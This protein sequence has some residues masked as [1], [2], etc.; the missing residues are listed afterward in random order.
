MCSSDLNGV[1]RL[2]K[3]LHEEDVSNIRVLHGDARLLLEKLGRNSIDKIFVLFPDPWPKARHHKK[4]IINQN[5]L[6]LICSVLKK[7]GILEVA[8]DH[9]E[10]GQWIGEH[11]EEFVGLQKERVSNEPPVD[12][13]RTNYQAKAEKQGRGATFFKY[14]NIV[15]KNS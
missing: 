11:L 3:Y 5:M 9:V 2:L 8:T 1:A 15:E 10:Y 7:G 4:R 6:G 13:V 12:W 14:L